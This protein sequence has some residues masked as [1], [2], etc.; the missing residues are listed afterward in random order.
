MLLL[1]PTGEPLGV[2]LLG[3]EKTLSSSGIS[4]LKSEVIRLPVGVLLPEGVR[5][6]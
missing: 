2:L 6:I 3:V 5:L 1:P 4:T